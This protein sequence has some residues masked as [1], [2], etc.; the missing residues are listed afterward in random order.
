MCEQCAEIDEKIERYRRITRLVSD[1]VTLERTAAL[2]TDFEAQK[3]ALHF[4]EQK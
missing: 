4:D 3:A 2:L 1:Q